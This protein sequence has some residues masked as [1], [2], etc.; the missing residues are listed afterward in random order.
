MKRAPHIRQTE[1][2]FRRQ[3]RKELKAAI[4]AVRDLTRGA[5]CLPRGT[6]STVVLAAQLLDAVRDR[7]KDW[8]RGY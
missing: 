2:Q 4:K 6:L 7:C 8:W 1:R 5:A 3:K